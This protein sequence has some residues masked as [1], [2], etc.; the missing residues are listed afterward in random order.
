MHVGI[1]GR[2][3]NP[4]ASCLAAEI[5]DELER[6]GVAEVRL[7]TA[8]ADAIGATPT[9]V[10]EM[11]ACDLLVSI[12]GDGTFLFAAREAG[13]TPILGINLG[14]VGFLNAVPPTDA[15]DAVLAEVERFRETGAV[16]SRPVPRLEAVGEGWTI[17]TAVNEI[18]IQGPQRGHGQGVELEVRVDG[19]LYSGGRGDG[20]LVATSTGSTAYN[21]SEGGPL[22]HP[23]VEAL[24]VTEMATDEP[25]PPLVAEL[26]S[27]ITV[28]ADGAPH[29]IVSS[30]GTLR[31]VETPATVRI[32]VA[33][34]P[35]RL[36]G[37]RVD[38]FQALNKLE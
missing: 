35:A 23:D 11:H 16:R 3:G 38:F 21:L 19:A 33:D 14:E 25:M 13:D 12:G 10:E 34:E 28:R 31:E 20:V 30:D 18:G 2:K 7:D 4:R 6:T 17:H 22:V 1:V 24:V 15:L 9:P 37:P 8:T 36:A 27:E 26:G 29:A 32:R 5:R